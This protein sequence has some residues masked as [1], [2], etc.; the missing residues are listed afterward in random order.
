MCQ[1]IDACCP[2]AC[3]AHIA[4]IAP[5]VRSSSAHH[6]SAFRGMLTNSTLVTIQTLWNLRGLSTRPLRLSQLLDVSHTRT[7]KTHSPH[8]TSACG[9]TKQALPTSTNQSQLLRATAPT[10]GAGDL[11]FSRNT[12]SNKHERSAGHMYPRATKSSQ[13]RGTPVALRTMRL[14]VFKSAACANKRAHKCTS[15]H[16]RRRRFR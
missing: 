2:R 9:A 11:N 13:A 16:V 4:Q 15:C 6:T 3:Q 12:E 10:R 1:N 14:R 5:C 7:K 8:L